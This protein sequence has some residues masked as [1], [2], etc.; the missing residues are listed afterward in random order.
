VHF[1]GRGEG[2]PVDGAKEAFR[3]I[4][5]EGFVHL[6]TLYREAGHEQA[7]RA[8]ITSLWADQYNLPAK[9]IVELFPFLDRGAGPENERWVAQLVELARGLRSERPEVFDSL[10]SQVEEDPSFV[11][12]LWST[13]ST[14]SP[15]AV[16]EKEAIFPLL[17]KEAFERLLCGKPEKADLQGLIESAESGSEAGSRFQERKDEMVGALTIY[18]QIREKNSDLKAPKNSGPEAFKRWESLFVN[19]VSP[20]PILQERL[21]EKLEHIG[22]ETPP[23]LRQEN[24]AMEGKLHDISQCFGRY[25]RDALS[26][27]EKAEGP[28]PTMIQDIPAILSKKRGAPDHKQVYY[29]LMDGM[30]WDLWESIKSDFF[31]KMSNHF[32][33]VREGIL[34]ASQPTDTAAQ[35]AHLDQA[36]GEIHEDSGDDNLLWKISGIDEKIHSEK[37]PLTHLFANVIGYLEI[38]LLFRLRKLPS[39]TLLIVFSDH[40]FV[41]NPAFRVADKYE[42]PRY[43]HGKDS[44]FEVIVPWAWVMRL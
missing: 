24:K 36:F 39:R 2:E 22:T 11:N 6:S 25:Y 40:G 15:I 16:F 29:L 33:F 41:E 17:L 4:L 14:T 27:W 35:L 12:H 32:R 23:F 34:W 5:E 28:R 3:E 44:P 42:A 19:S 21:H 43:I 1:L 9:K 7:A 30:R 37:G 8:A 13:L 20:L 18:H 26:V 38:D 31:G 10:A